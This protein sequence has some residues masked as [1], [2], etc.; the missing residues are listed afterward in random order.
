MDFYTAERVTFFQIQKAL[1]GVGKR[2]SSSEDSHPI[3]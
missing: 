3:A 1:Q 2:L